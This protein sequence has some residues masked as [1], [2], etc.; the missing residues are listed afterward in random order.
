MSNQSVKPFVE[1]RISCLQNQKANEGSTSNHDRSRFLHT[2]VLVTKPPTQSFWCW[3]T[4]N[5]PPEPSRSWYIEVKKLLLLYIQ[6]HRHLNSVVFDWCFSPR[7]LDR[8]SCCPWVRGI[9]S[10]TGY[11]VAFV[12]HLQTLN[13]ANLLQVPMTSL[14]LTMSLNS[15]C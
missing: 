10:C 2:A 1:H 3:W 11:S 14:L 12:V 4:E 6:I 15:C 8:L 7:M 9:A 5:L 13:P